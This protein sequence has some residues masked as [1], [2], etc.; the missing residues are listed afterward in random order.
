MVSDGIHTFKEN[1]YG[2]KSLSMAHQ[3]Y[4]SLLAPITV[5]FKGPY[6][7]VAPY[8]TKADSMGVR[9]LEGLEARFPVVKQEMSTVKQRVHS[10]AMMP[11][12]IATN[13]KDYVFRTY[14]SEFQRTHGQG[15]MRQ[16]KAAI[17]TELKIA[18]DVLNWISEALRHKK[19]EGAKLVDEKMNH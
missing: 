12:T 11:L 15:V 9:G 10:T 4:A 5:Y 18:I 16:A 17:S 6:A 7:Y 1:P 8:L 19:E 3:A 2:A 14:D 13:G